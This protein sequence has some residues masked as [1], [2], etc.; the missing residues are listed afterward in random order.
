MRE[1]AS[2]AS[3]APAFAPQ[4]LRRARERV[5]ESEGPS[6]SDKIRLIRIHAHV[7]GKTSPVDRVDP[8]WLAPDSGVSIWVDLMNPAP[9]EG[10][11]ILSNVFHFHDLAVEDALSDLQFPKVESYGDYLYLILHRIDFS[12]PEHCFKTHDVDFFLASRYLVT[13]HSG[14]SRSIEQISRICERN[15]MALGEG[16]A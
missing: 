2:R 14:D 11:D 12:A 16:T 1:R 6:P 8:A 13:I 4:A 5:G 15:S 10:R 7:N 3:H 9:E